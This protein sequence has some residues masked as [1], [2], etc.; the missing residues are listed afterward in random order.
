MSSESVSTG[1][2]GQP[3]QREGVASGT[4]HGGVDAPL[5]FGDWLA[6]YGAL[7]ESAG[8]ASLARRT[9]VELTGPERARFLNRL[10]TN[11]LDDLSTGGGRETFL[12]DAKGH[13]VAH[14][15]VF[16]TD[17]SLVL[18]TVGGEADRLIAH[19]GHYLLRE[20]VEIADHSA[21][22]HE[23]LVAGSRCVELLHGLAGCK[24]TG[25]FFGRGEWAQRDSQ[26]GRKMSQS[27]AACGPLPQELLAHRDVPLAGT[28]VSLRRLDSV[29]TASFA[30]ACPAE[31]ARAVWNV[32]CEAGA[33]ACGP[34]AV[35][36][37]RIESGWPEF[38]RDVTQENL[39]QE[40]GR[41]D[42]TISFTKG[43]YLGQET[44]ARIQS[45][46]H[47]NQTLV[48]LKFHSADVPPAGTALTVEGR[49]A[50]SVTSAA[51][52]P[53]LASAIALGYVRR[54]HTAA[55]THLESSFGP[56]EVSALPIR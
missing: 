18:D 15:L 7:R 8:I 17:N 21:H 22:W 14:L 40:V 16:A 4:S 6:E 30:L 28:T 54:G 9:Q 53:R 33:R 41:I 27:P 20:A 45:R 23:F 26:T 46:G 37:F 1:P 55:G 3:N 5:D 19:L 2:F 51:F 29:S 31:T 24:G 32:M 12:C 13:I 38:G 34:M 49:P 11:R 50:G 43:C 36:P 52:S 39:P 10:S 25:T 42:R 47:V 48:G 44:V 56:V 35:E